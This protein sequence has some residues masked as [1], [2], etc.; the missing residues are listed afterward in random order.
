MPLNVGSMLVKAKF[1]AGNMM[2]GLSAMNSK[3]KESQLAAK[4]ATTQFRRMKG[5][6]MA[7]GAS[8]ALTSGA[9]LGMLMNAIMQSPFL[10]AAMEKLKTQMM[11][12]GNAIARHLA[13]I[14]EKV[15]DFVKW[16]REKFQALPEPIQAAIV[17]F[18]AIGIIIIGLISTLGI[19]GVIL[20]GIKTGLVTLGLTGA[21]TKLG[22][23]ATA[24]LGSTVAATLLGVGIGMLAGIIGVAVLDRSGALEWVSNIGEG[25]RNWNSIIRDVIA[26]LSGLIALIGGAAIDISRGDWGFSTT[27]AWL[28]Q[29]KEAKD[30]V[31]GALTG[32]YNQ[33]SSTTSAAQTWSAYNT[34]NN[35]NLDPDFVG[36][37]NKKTE[38]A[39]QNNYFDFSGLTNGTPEELVEATN[40]FAET[41]AENQEKLNP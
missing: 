7:M 21:I 39:A 20:G 3:F 27:K 19:F 24:F 9:L 34:P 32:S 23:L 14:L 37:E 41:L 28:E 10:S 22:A 30:R 17:K 1:E 18:A 16:L 25:F 11:L 36:P 29:W 15:V 38:I 31:T 33:E 35:Q 6:L 40:L 26:T 4:Q 5:S 13:P 12:F 2:S 8:A